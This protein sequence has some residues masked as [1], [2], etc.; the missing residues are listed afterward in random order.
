MFNKEFRDLTIIVPTLNEEATIKLLM[1]EISKIV[2]KA[3]VIIADDGSSDKTE[4]EVESFNGDLNVFFLDRSKEPVHGLTV[5]VLDAIKHTSTPYFLVMDGDMQHP[6][7]VLPLFYEN[8]ING[9][10]LVVG[11]R[12]KVLGGWPLHRKLISYFATILG[13]ISLF[14]HGRNMT[15]DIMSGFFAS[16]SKVWK[17]FINNDN[18]FNKFCLKGYKVLFDFLKLYPNKLVIKEVPYIFGTRHFGASKINKKIVWLFFK[19]LF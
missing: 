6:V 3:S 4:D 2:P 5:S 13:R 14:I 10:Q 12:I 11:K 1:N 7:N 9:A 15:S 17:E 19:S 8:L 16:R 18:N